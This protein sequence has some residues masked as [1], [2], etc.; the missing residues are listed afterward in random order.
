MNV[1]PFFKDGHWTGGRGWRREEGG[2]L[3]K[4]VIQSVLDQLGDGSGGQ[5]L[6]EQEAIRMGT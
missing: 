1:K 4:M 5:N 2:E 3:G 6:G